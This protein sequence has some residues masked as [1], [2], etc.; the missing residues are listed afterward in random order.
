[1]DTWLELDVL[2]VKDK[3]CSG[4]G[5]EEPPACASFLGFRHKLP[6]L[7]CEADTLCKHEKSQI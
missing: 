4:L 7:H 5:G 3:A 6:H 2:L 1:M